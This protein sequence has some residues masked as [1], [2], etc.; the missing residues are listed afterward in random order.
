MTEL[1]K[2]AAD[3]G[4]RDHDHLPARPRD[5]RRDRVR[6]RRPGR[7]PARDGVPHP[8][9]EDR[10]GRRARRDQQRHLPV[11]RRHR[12]LRPPPQRQQGRGAQES[13]LL[14]G[15]QRGGPG[16]DRDAV[17]QL[18]P[19]V[20]LQLRQQHQHPRGRLPPLR[21]PLRPDPDPQR[22]RPQQ[23]SAER[24]KRRQPRRRGRARGSD[25]GDLGQ[26]ARP[27]VRGPDQDQT[28]Q[29][30]DPRPGRGDRQPQAGRVPRGEP[31]PTRNA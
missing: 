3:L 25:R 5:L 22:L 19:G 11:R 18:L 21:L 24:E 30:A 13:H 17:E 29:P 26:A 7:A 27:A 12:G 15:R 31:R 14:R 16:R 20:D 9:P 1:T 23:R 28:R 2:A 8:R 6:L 10:A 4:A